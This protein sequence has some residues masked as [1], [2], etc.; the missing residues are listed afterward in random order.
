MMKKFDAVGN[1]FVLDGEP[2]RLMAGAM[3][4][5]RV[6][7]EYWEDRMR[8]IKALGLNTLETYVCWNLHEP[9]PGEFDFE[10]MLDIVSYIELA[11]RLGLKV[12]VRPGPYIC[13][14]WDM[15]GLPP[16]L[17]KDPAMQIRCGYPP[18]LKAVDRFFD[19][20]L[21]KLAPLQI[22]GGGPIIAMQIENE[23]GSYGNDKDYLLHIESEYRKHGL[24][25]L[26]FTSDNSSAIASGGGELPH[27]L[28]TANFGRNAK[29]RFAVLRERKPEGPLMCM[30]FWNGWFDAWGDKHHTREPEEVAASLDEVLSMGGHFCLYMVHGGTNFGFMSGANG[31]RDKYVST[32]TSYDS[33]API[34][35]YG[36]LT[37]KY[38]AIRDTITKYEDLPE[39]QDF[40]PVETAS[41]GEVSLVQSV[42]LRMS[43]NRL[44]QSVHSPTPV[45]MEMLDQ[46]YGC[47]LY[48]TRVNGPFLQKPLTICDLHDRAHI[49]L[50]GKRIAI[51]EREHPSAE[52]LLLDIPQQG[53][54]LEILVE[55]MGRINYGPS[56]MDRKGITQRVQV[57]GQVLFDWKIYPLPLTDLAHLDLRPAQTPIEE[58]TFFRGRVTVKNP[59]D[60][61][62]RLEGWTK[63]VAWVN[64]HNLG[65]YWNRGPQQT[66]YVPGVWLREGSNEVT[67]LELDAVR[68]SVVAM[69]AEPILNHTP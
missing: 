24:D 63:G 37:P 33:H 38:W 22:S 12:I 57:G 60:T 49:F 52:P 18:Y 31:D 64:G 27:I 47:I 45:P 14:E 51:Q 21:P 62:L 30:E 16:W 66:L 4:Y 5:F 19:A 42:S 20:L 9:R 41:Y 3:H 69:V 7:R 2:I 36:E 44:S 32:I 59:R 29:E 8:K 1:D 48:R 15:G 28:Q 55:N 17:L 25:L 35:E 65:W 34:N 23:Y 39:P 53:A 43:L 58:P 13:S 68:E 50:N 56:M 67:V 11:G 61:F 26:L 46:N 6:P 54:D 10:G 40:P